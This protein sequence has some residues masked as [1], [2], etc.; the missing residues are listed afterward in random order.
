MIDD[1]WA[2][3]PG[4][5]ADEPVDAIYAPALVTFFTAADTCAWKP[6][7]CAQSAHSTAGGGRMGELACA[8]VSK[9]GVRSEWEGGVTIFISSEVASKASLRSA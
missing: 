8:Q 6:H 5:E 9:R 7:R 2:W 3:I 1:R 4:N